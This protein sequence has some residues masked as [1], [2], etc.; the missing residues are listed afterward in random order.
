MK[1]ERQQL[2]RSRYWDGQRLRSEDFRANQ[3]IE[4]QR[5]WWHNRA[6][7][8]AFGI[9]S[10]LLVTP[11]GA[12]VDRVTV[13]PGVGY[14]CFGRELVL[15]Q[16][17][18]LQLPAQFAESIYLVIRYVQNPVSPAGN[19]WQTTPKPV[20]E[21]VEFIWQP[22]R[23][24]NFTDGVPLAEVDLLG[25]KPVFSFDF[26]RPP[27]RPQARPL[28]A[29]GTTIPGKTPWVIDDTRLGDAQALQASTEID[30]SAGGFTAVP[31]Y[32]AWLQGPLVDPKTSE[33]LRVIVSRVENEAVDKFRFSYWFVATRGSFTHASK[34]PPQV[35]RTDLYVSWIGCQMPP[36]L[37]FVQPSGRG[38]NQFVLNSLINQQL[39]NEV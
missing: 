24:F 18:S 8:Q 9:A 26:F 13:S 28:I 14:D 30:T 34:N 37:P 35:R 6:E 33:R 2:E 15:E 19:C 27:P 36:A 21:F 17:R 10:G 39:R 7:H 16:E 11:F 22:K 12:T 4:E 31:C 25:G 20:A 38:S 29:V 5:R 23:L 32:F 3:R 1:L